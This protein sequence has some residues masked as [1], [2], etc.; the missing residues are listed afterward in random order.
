MGPHIEAVTPMLSE[1]TGNE[2]P[3]RIKLFLFIEILPAFSSCVST[4]HQ[5][6]LH[7]RLSMPCLRHQPRELLHQH[8]RVH[9]R[10]FCLRP[11]Q[12][13]IKATAHLIVKRQEYDHITDSLCD[14]LHVLPVQY[15]HTYKLCL[16]VHKCLHGTASSYIIDQ[17]IPVMV[18][19]AH[20]S[21]RSVTDH[22]F[23][24]L[25]TNLVCF[26]QCSFGIISPIT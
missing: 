16:L 3:R 2:A 15:R 8:P 25:R 19:P 4:I 18:N 7:E 22:D 26:G 12:S 21:L 6:R 10:F 23:M 17:C 14:E 24:Y 1:H 11:L 20:S 5:L 13:V 9:K